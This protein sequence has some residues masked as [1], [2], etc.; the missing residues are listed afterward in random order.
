[1]TDSVI[2]GAVEWTG[3]NPFI[4]LAEEG[5]SGWSS[6]SLMFRIAWSGLGTGNA[7]LVLERPRQTIGRDALLGFCA[8]DNE[9]LAR[10]LVGRF[11]RRFGVFR[12]AD[13]LQLLQFVKARNFRCGESTSNSYVAECETD[14]Y[15]KVVLSWGRLRSPFAVDVPASETATG[16]H[17]M[18]SV[19]RP[20]DEAVVVVDG[21][22]QPGGVRE[23]DFFGGQSMSAGLAFSETWIR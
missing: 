21:R 14:E 18:L 2:K 12:D 1:M 16:H 4:Y 7:I 10:D 9:K 20:A 6:L 5:G 11:V 17:I 3:D 19:F 23:R 13:A 22:P 15:G 8:S